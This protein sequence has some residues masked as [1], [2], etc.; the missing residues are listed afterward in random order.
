MKDRLKIK[1][2]TGAKENEYREIR[3]SQKW[4]YHKASYKNLEFFREEPKFASK[5]SSSHVKKEIR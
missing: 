4:Y 5:F 3:L 1:Q 2:R